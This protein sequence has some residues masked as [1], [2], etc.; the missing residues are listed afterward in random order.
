MRRNPRRRDQRT[1]RLTV[2]LRPRGR[3]PR[4]LVASG[5]L[6]LPHERPFPSGAWCRRSGSAASLISFRAPPP[7]VRRQALDR[8]ERVDS[9]EP[10]L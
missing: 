6:Y 7:L 9:R 4:A 2:L 8:N 3:T 1:P 10:G 5:I